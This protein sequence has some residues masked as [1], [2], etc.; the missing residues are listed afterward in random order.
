MLGYGAAV[1]GNRLLA[2]VATN[3]DNVTIGRVLGAT[4]LGYYGLAYRLML[5]PIQRIGR[6]PCLRPYE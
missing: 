3:A 1:S 5:T 2:Y 6:V 4:P